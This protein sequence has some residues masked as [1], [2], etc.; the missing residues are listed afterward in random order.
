MSP[1]SIRLD[2]G[3]FVR[4]YYGEKTGERFKAMAYDDFSPEEAE[5]HESHLK[6]NKIDYLR[7]EL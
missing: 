3:K 6:N 5:T 7:I 4:F 2:S 1:S